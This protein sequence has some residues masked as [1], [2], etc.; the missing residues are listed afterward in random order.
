[1]LDEAAVPAGNH[2]PEERRLLE[3]LDAAEPQVLECYEIRAYD[4]ALKGLLGLRAPIDAFFEDVMV[5]AEDPAAR[6]RRLKLLRRIQ[7]LFLR[8]WDFSQVSVPAAV[9]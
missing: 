1:A 3:A 7:R 6:E 9:S 2:D 8:G 4:R 5:L